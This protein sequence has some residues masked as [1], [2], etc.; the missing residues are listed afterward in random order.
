MSGGPCEVWFYHLERS[1]L[2]QVLPELLGRTLAR[3]WRA[4]VCN[5]DEAF[6]KRLDEHL[7]TFRDES[8]LAHGPAGDSFS[9]RQPILISAAP[10][11]QNGAQ[12]LFA[13]G[14]EIGELEG[15]DRCILIFDG[16]DAAKVAA[17]REAWKTCKARN[18][19]VS[20]WRQGETGGWSR[21]A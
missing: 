15:F 5:P 3:G 10:T 16:H 19:P 21:E 14:E 13:L 9:S 17:A 18:L 12:A 20:Y 8:F 7:W 6:R 1:S 4:E 2:E 11:R